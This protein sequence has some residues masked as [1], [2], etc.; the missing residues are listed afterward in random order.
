M[1]IVSQ[2]P[3]YMLSLAAS[4]KTWPGICKYDCNVACYD[5]A[6][7]GMGASIRDTLFYPGSLE[8]FNESK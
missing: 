1:L 7:L 3:V 5:V 4:T 2:N 8:V 6:A